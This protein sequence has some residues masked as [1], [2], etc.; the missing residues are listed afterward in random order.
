MRGLCDM[1]LEQLAQ[2]VA[3]D[4]ADDLRT[5]ATAALDKRD[6]RRLVAGIPPSHAALLSPDIGLICF[7]GSVKLVGREMS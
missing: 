4:L 1:L 3:G 6:D 2:G 7:D 5:H